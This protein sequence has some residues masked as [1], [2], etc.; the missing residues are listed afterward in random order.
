MDVLFWMI[1]I[2]LVIYA[3]MLILA[4]LMSKSMQRS[5][6]RTSVTIRHILNFW[7]EVCFIPFFG[8]ICLLSM[9]VLVGFEELKDWIMTTKFWDKIQNILN[10]EI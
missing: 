10:K 8:P 3:V 6:E 1:G 2:H 4:Y 5:G 9:I 7:P